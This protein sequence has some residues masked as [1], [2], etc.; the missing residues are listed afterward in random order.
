MIIFLCYIHFVCEKYLAILHSSFWDSLFESIFSS[1]SIIFVIFGVVNTAPELNT[2]ASGMLSLSSKP[3][4]F[5]WFFFHEIFFWIFFAFYFVCFFGISVLISSISLINSSFDSIFSSDSLLFLFLFF[6][7]IFVAFWFI[8]VILHFN[9][10]L[11][12]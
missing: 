8:F 10:S 9:S 3:S 2:I 7:Y 11:K 12:N 1:S 5:F 4:G 6:Y